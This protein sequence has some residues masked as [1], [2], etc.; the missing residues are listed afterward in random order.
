MKLKPYIF[1]MAIDKTPVHLSAL[2]Q[3]LNRSSVDEIKDIFGSKIIGAG[4]Y[5]TVYDLGNNFILKVQ[6]TQNIQPKS[7]KK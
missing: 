6:S 1:E 2:V 3:K 7:K 5:K 4:S